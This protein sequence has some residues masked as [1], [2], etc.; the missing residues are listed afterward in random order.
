VK[1]VLRYTKGGGSSTDC[2]INHLKP[3][4]R[5]HEGENHIYSGTGRDPIT[6]CDKG[7]EFFL[8]LQGRGRK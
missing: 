4:H 6:N 7:N 8:R 3:K 1:F 2:L 5:I